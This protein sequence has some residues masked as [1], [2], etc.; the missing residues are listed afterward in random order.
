[1]IP[2][3]ARRLLPRALLLV[4]GALALPVSAAAQGAAADPCAREPDAFACTRAREWRQ[5]ETWSN[6]VRREAG[7]LILQ[8]DGGRRLTLTDVPASHGPESGKP[9]AERE[10]TYALREYVPRMHAYVVELAFRDGGAFTLI[11]AGS[12]RQT[13]LNGEPRFS[14]DGAR[15]VEASQADRT[16]TVPSQISVWRTGEGGPVRE[17]QAKPAP[18]EAWD[19]AEPVWTSTS[20]IRFLR[21][22]A[23]RAGF[24]L[25][26]SAALLRLGPAGWEMTAGR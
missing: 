10:T 3:R 8:L 11:D 26:E 20:T 25:R 24:S 16:G 9:V 12:G 13:P 6:L 17:F 22:S 23:D 4:A 18:G 2:L 21:R 15:F 5:V 19:P 14:P 7:A 1:M